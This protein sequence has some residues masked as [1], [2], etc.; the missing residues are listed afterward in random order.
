MAVNTPRA[1]PDAR[2]AEPR[3]ARVA[4][5][6]CLMSIGVALCLSLAACGG[7]DDSA[8]QASNATSNAASPQS[9]SPTVANAADPASNGLAPK[10]MHYAQ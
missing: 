7:H 8:T 3:I 6:L 2:A 9:D 10:V 4:T 5:A 1:V